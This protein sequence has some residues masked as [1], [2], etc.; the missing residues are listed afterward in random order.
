[1]LL[2]HRYT[3]RVEG[4]R[5][6]PNLFTIVLHPRLFSCLDI[7]PV[8]SRDCLQAW[9]SHWVRRWTSNLRRRAM[10]KR[11]GGGD[12]LPVRTACKTCCICSLDGAYRAD[13]RRIS[14][15]FSQRGR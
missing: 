15:P 12:S 5:N 14:T 8:L 10:A 4:E 13:L 7:C 6:T 11:D 3:L 1:M 9:R 2:R